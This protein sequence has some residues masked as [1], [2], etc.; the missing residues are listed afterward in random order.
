MDT[1][2]WANFAAVTRDHEHHFLVERA[3]ALVPAGKQKRYALDLGC[4]AGRNTRFL[5][6][7]GWHVTAVD[8]EP[9]A[10]AIVS[11]IGNENLRVVRSRFEDFEFGEARYY[12]VCAQF[13]LPF[14]P[15]DKFPMVWA[16][17]RR[18]IKPGGYFEGQFFGTH[19]EWNTPGSNVNFVTR[20]EV[21]ELLDGLTLVEIT[22]EDKEGGTATGAIKHWHVFHV[23]A[24]K[25]MT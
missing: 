21:G 16:G 14:T 1:F 7:R 5:L 19:D 23:I 17:L 22:E 4:G 12:L 20:E 6:S 11:K 9:E 10:I 2:D 3:E 24:K 8:A 15:R 25:D 13:T 18:A